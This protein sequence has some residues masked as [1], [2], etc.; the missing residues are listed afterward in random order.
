[1]SIKPN[2]DEAKGALKMNNVYAAKMRAAMGVVKS[3]NKFRASLTR[4]TQLNTATEA[5]RARL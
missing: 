5:D 3:Y 2:L 4:F 1:M